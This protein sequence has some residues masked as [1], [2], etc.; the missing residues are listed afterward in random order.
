[1][2]ENILLVW[3]NIPESVNCYIL[4]EGSDIANLAI[5]SAGKYI[6]GDDVKEG[7][8]IEKLNDALSDIKSLETKESLIGPFSK[9]V[10]CGFIS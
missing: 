2:A 3:E 1:M 10:I 6:N 8:P 5:K 4:E 9:V 7:D